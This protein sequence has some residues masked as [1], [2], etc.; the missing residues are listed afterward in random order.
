[1]HNTWMMSVNLLYRQY[2]CTI[3]GFTID[4]KP[5]VD[6]SAFVFYLS[7]LQHQCFSGTPVPSA[8][9]VPFCC[10]SASLLYQCASGVSV[11]LC[12]TSAPQLYP[13]LPAVQAPLL[14]QCPSAVPVPLRLYKCPSAV[15]VLLYCTSALLLYQYSSALPVTLCYTTDPML[16][17]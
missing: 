7:F 14:H 12:C 6:T 3:I 11:P 15:P 4:I 16:Y 5:I 2:P 10:T 8:V 9:P 1:M 17:Q 13:C